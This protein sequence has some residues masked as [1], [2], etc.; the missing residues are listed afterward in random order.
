MQAYFQ[1]LNHL[2]RIFIL[3]RIFHIVVYLVS[4]IISLQVVTILLLQN[5]Q[6]QTLATRMVAAFV[7]DRFG[8]DISIGEIQAGF[9]GT[10]Y[11]DDLNIYDR[12]GKR[13]VGV[14]KL[15]VRIG[16]I[17]RFEKSLEFGHIRIEG[18][19]FILRNYS[20]DQPGNFEYF[21]SH[22]IPESDG[23]SK[24]NSKA[25][26][27]KLICNDLSIRNSH[28]IYENQYRKLPT[29]SI[30]FEDMELRDID[31][32][33]SDVF[34]DKDTISM[35]F[36][37]LAFIEKSGFELKEFSGRARFS[38]VNL[39]VDQLLISTNNSY[40][41]LD[42]E[43]EYDSLSAFNDFIN[44][45]RFKGDFRNSK[46]EMSDIGYFAETMF[47]MTDS[48]R[49][50]GHIKGTV[51]NILGSNLEIKYADNTNFAGDVSM[52]GLP[53]IAETFIHADIDNFTTTATNVESF[54]LPG[55]QQRIVVPALL[56]KMG[57]VNVS[58]KFTGFYND[59][60]SNAS[61]KTKLGNLKTNIVLKTL[62][63]DNSLSYK[64][65]LK[66]TNLD[67]GTLLSLN[68][69]LG[70]MNFSLDVDGKGI[71]LDALDIEAKGVI[72]SL[73]FNAYDYK[74]I[75]LD[76]SFDNMV[77]EGET[78]IRDQNLDFS[79]SGLIDFK[80]ERP[81]FDF[82]SSI[83]R[84][85]LNALKLSQRDSIGVLSTEMQCD[86][87]ATS[88]NDIK[89]MVR[90][91]ST[92]YTEGKRAYSLDSLIVT[93]V[94]HNNGKS[95]LTLSSDLI[96]LGVDG[97]YAISQIVPAVK[98]YILNFSGNLAAKLP[99]TNDAS[100]QQQIE[101]NL[102]LKDSDPLTQLFV[103]NITVAPNASL[104]GSVDLLGMQTQINAEASFLKLPS[105][106]IL[107]LNMNALSDSSIFNTTFFFNKIMLRE[108]DESDSLGVGIDSLSIASGLYNDTINFKISWNDL[109]NQQSNIGDVKGYFEIGKGDYYSA[110]IEDA[111]MLFDSAVW[112]VQEGNKIVS[113]SMGLSFTDLNFINDT[114]ML[115]ISGGISMSPL[116][117]LKL[118]FR[119]LDISHVDRLFRNGN[120]D[121]DG[122]I[123]GGLTFVNLYMTPNLLADIQLNDL[124]FNGEEMGILQLNTNWVDALS[125]LDVNLLVFREGNLG[126]SEVLSAK[127]EYYPT[128]ADRNFD[129]DIKLENL[130]TQIFNPFITEF[131]DISSESLASGLL[132]LSGTYFKPVLKGEIKLSRTQVLVKYLNTYYSAAGT[133]DVGEN[134]IDVADLK[135][136]DIRGNSADCS[137]RITHNYF[138][139]FYFDV[140]IDQDN[141]KALNTTF[142]DNELF[143]G[144]AF[145]SGSVNITGPLNNIVMDI[146]ARTDEGTDVTIPISSVLSVSENDFIIF[147]NA[148]DTLE[149]EKKRYNLNVEG[150][151]VNME[152]DVTPD[153]D[154]S[155]FL[156]YNM[157]DINGT[158]SGNIG[159]GV[160]SRGDFSINGEYVIDDGKFNFSFENLLKKQ[161][162]IRKGSKI[163]WYGDPYDATVNIT[164]THKV[165]TSLMGLRLQTDSTTI[166]NKRIDVDCNIML[167]NSLFNPDI[168][169]SFDLRNVDD[170]T[171]QIIFAAL[172]TTDQSLMSQQIVSL[173]FI[174]SFSYA[175]A[176][177]G[178]GASGFKLLS[179]QVSNWLSKI[180]K[181]F[182]IGVNYQPGTELTQ[183]ELEVALRTQLF[184]DRL[185]I[186][187][188]FGVRG[189]SQEQNTSNVVGDINVEYQIT[190]DGRFR[191]KAFNRSNEIS[192]LEDNAPYT[193]GVGIFYRKEFEKLKDL[194]TR[195]RE[196]KKN[197][198]K[199]SS[200]QEAVINKNDDK[201]ND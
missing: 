43:F 77:F 190:K 112:H 199:E 138:Q 189:T 13:M 110:G 52:N 168:S 89:G 70:K 41:D 116:D 44:S 186:D 81:R 174:G 197:E 94:Q 12:K 121:V 151:S 32:L 23:T 3:K 137:G 98:N 146:R 69:K 196:K 2:N 200:N 154:I 177:P 195:D 111:R 130:G 102:L 113:D 114:S 76:G 149:K 162:D 73:Y 155:I 115:S 42:L 201:K 30:D 37:N 59:F 153:A 178:I 141:F 182:D 185:S 72:Q 119:K 172:D 131:V 50:H 64:G 171:R 68:P 9:F 125:K 147:L 188:N 1:F 176:G 136:Y 108:P 53:D 5:P 75:V 45:V 47:D 132:K 26:P 67:A 33:A 157:G 49:F 86:F 78:A 48:L 198:K 134:Y 97:N 61:F 39:K 28:F 95:G 191:I 85:N 22:F 173:I 167:K 122:V 161:F 80:D 66:A 105:M 54:A 194:F 11:L 93:S 104:S 96:D 18:V 46:L 165:N 20:P 99:G 82:H 184:N 58:G 29:K 15:D 142:R 91:D 129:V 140:K 92:I 84:M 103:P 90:F 38:P 123:N 65:S 17:N 133:V 120:F 14:E 60:V 63:A 179:N 88:I 158:G 31:L 74:N 166:R 19:E 145:A 109:S 27:W 193:Q 183:D 106:K 118:G 16:G 128:D 79:F 34:L 143:Y 51:T 25:T 169:F 56:F 160:N 71:T 40:L 117:S 124:F 164:A 36:R 148:V 159:L 139:D 181:D 21:L 156:P 10:F 87:V 107:D 7:N 35:S 150:F 144:T 100:L 135:I 57:L 62:K 170:D 192:F 24:P 163:T 83:G 55:G 187:G 152:L 180:S 6:A 8:T 4:F 126:I 127:G 101:F 175:S